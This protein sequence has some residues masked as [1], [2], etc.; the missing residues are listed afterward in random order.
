[1]RIRFK[2]L[3]ACLSLTSVT[4]ALGLFVLQGQRGLGSLA[5]SIYDDAVMSISYARSAE[6]RFVDLRGKLVM[7]HQRVLADESAGPRPGEAS[8]RQAM[9]AIA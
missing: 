1:M 3:L 7:S 2:I 4:I 9:L 8:E 5:M 6:T